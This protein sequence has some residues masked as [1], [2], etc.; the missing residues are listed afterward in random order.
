MKYY[1]YLACFFIIA[2]IAGCGQSQKTES[3]DKDEIQIS[4]QDQIRA[5]LKEYVDRVKE[6]DKTVLYENEFQ[7]YTD[8]VSLSMYMEMHYVLEY[9]YD[10]LHD[11]TIDTM[12][13]LGDSAVMIVKVEYLSAAGGTIARPYPMTVYRR[14]YDSVWVRPYQSKY[15]LEAEYIEGYKAYMEAIGKGSGE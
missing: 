13:M 1:K 10:S 14:P 5:M 6:G 11:I 4:E 15:A 12:L 8:S 2:I 3:G 9:K 7:Y